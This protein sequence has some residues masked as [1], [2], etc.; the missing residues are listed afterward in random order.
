MSKILMIL[1]L[2]KQIGPIIAAVKQIF[3]ALGGSGINLQGIL[4]ILK[5]IADAFGGSPTPAPVLAMTDGSQA[6]IDR[7]TLKSALGQLGGFLTALAAVTPNKLDDMIAGVLVSASQTDWLLDLIIK[8][9]GGQEITEELV[10]QA[11]AGQPITV[12]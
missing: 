8:V 2:L 6:L 11:I 9:I 3:D 4:D 1:A 7:D 5:K 12:A 10:N